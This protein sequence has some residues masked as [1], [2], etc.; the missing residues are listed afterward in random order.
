MTA[1]SPAVFEVRGWIG[2]GERRLSAEVSAGQ[3]ASVR[4]PD[5]DGL[6]Q[7][8]A[9]FAA[10]QM[11]VRIADSELGRLSARERAVAGLATVDATLPTTSELRVLDLLLLGRPRS[12][13]WGFLGLGGR[14]RANFMAQREAEARALA[15]RLGLGHLLDD[16]ASTLTAASATIVDLARALLAEPR[17]L[18]AVVPQDPEVAAWLENRLSAEAVSR[19]LPVL[20]LRQGRAG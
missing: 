12:G 4:V 1:V 16:P 5:P 14:G 19:N 8:I 20:L 18:V 6:L 15:G 17:A 9:G 2:P 7:R 10:P 13:P 11:W 3:C